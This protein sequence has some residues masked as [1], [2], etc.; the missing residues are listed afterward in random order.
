[1]GLTATHLKQIR[2]IAAR[3]KVGDRWRWYEKNPFFCHELARRLR[4]EKG[5]IPQQLG[6]VEYWLPDDPELASLC[7]RARQGDREASAQ[8]KLRIED[9][10][11]AV[12]PWYSGSPVT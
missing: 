9:W 7:D 3:F 6:C 4:E 8:L 11:V 2:R 1:M 12:P 5:L 10:G